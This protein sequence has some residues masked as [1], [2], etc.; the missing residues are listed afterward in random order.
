MQ[1]K[2]SDQQIQA[3]ATKLGAQYVLNLNS[4]VGGGFIEIP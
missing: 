3:I 4:E 2:H 1:Y